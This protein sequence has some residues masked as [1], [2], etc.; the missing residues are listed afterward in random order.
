MPRRAVAPTGL[1]FEKA[2][3]YFHAYMYGPLQGKL[4]LY[5]ARNIRSAGDATPSRRS[6]DLLSVCFAPLPVRS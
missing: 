5:A 3:M 6:G 4:R 2:L 1:D